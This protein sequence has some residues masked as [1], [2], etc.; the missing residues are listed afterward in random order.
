MNEALELND[1]LIDAEKAL[2]VGPVEMARKMGTPYSTYKKWRNGSRV[3]P[4]VA[5]KCLE[6]V[7]RAE[8]M[9]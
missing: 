9:G 8:G 3:M 7:L 2:N 4:A 1:E 6:L 5:E